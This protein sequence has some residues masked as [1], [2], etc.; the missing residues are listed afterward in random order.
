M[1]PAALRCA[2]GV[3]LAASDVPFRSVIVLFHD[4]GFEPHLDDV[5]NRTINDAF[6]DHPQVC[7]ALRWAQQD[8]TLK[9]GEVLEKALLYNRV[10]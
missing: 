3:C 6:G 2:F 8:L 10:G 9:V 5:K 1:N 4:R 7:E